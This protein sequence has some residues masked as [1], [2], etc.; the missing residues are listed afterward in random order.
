MEKKLFSEFP[1]ISKQQWEEVITADL[2]GADYNKKLVWKTDE[3]FSVRPYYVEEDIAELEYLKNFA[4]KSIS[5]QP[6]D[7]EIRQDFYTGD[8]AHLASEAVKRGAQSVGISVAVRNSSVANTDLSTLLKGIDPLTTGI[9]FTESTSVPDTMSAFAE[10]LKN[11]K[12][13]STKVYG[14]ISGCN[15]DADRV[16]KE[17]G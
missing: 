7:W 15:K 9:H 2:K 13:D 16:L 4:G 3:G 8:I 12:I 10:Y 1:P 17:Y 11:N 14:S 6:N 5:E